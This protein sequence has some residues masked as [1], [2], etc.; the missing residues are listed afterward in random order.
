MIF[1][2]AIPFLILAVL[3]L[4]LPFILSFF[5][6]G[7]LLAVGPRGEP[8]GACAVI[9]RFAGPTLLRSPPR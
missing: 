6:F 9:S 3:F 2:S 7:V 4:P 5:F 1:R 8:D